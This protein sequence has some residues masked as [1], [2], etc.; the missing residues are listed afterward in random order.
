MQKLAEREAQ[1]RS[2]GSEDDANW[3]WGTQKKFLEEHILAWVPRFCAKVIEGAE[4]PFYREMAEVTRSFL[5]FENDGFQSSDPNTVQT[6][7]AQS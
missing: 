3:C 2:E 5:E 7:S 1:S 4:Q 6:A